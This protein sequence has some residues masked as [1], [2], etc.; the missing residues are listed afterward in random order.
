M[1]QAQISSQVLEYR[2]PTLATLVTGIFQPIT[3]LCAILSMVRKDILLLVEKAVLCHRSR[4]GYI[5]TLHDVTSDEM[6]PFE[7]QEG[8]KE[9]E[10]LRK[11][12]V[13]CKLSQ[14]KGKEVSV[15]NSYIW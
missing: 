13:G 3:P 1:N 2:N 4:G 8:K 11:D 10:G 6:L 5:L 14:E 9:D 7:L 15:I 12:E